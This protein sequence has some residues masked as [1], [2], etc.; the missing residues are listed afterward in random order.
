[1]IAPVVRAGECRVWWADPW[2]QTIGTLTET[3]SE[4]EL[5][6]AGRF[7]R[8]QDRR[9]YLTGAWLLRTVTAR[10]LGIEPGEVS[11]DR[12]CPGCAKMHGKPHIRDTPLH[13]SVT[14]SADRVGVALTTAGPLG[15]DVEAVPAGSFDDLARCALSPAESLAVEAVPERERHAAFTGL[16]VRKEAVLKATGHGLRIPPEQV[17]MT[18]PFDPAP[19]LLR[20]P[21]TI[22]PGGVRI[23]LLHPGAGYAGALAVITDDA[24]SVA[25]SYI[26]RLH[27]ARSAVAVT[28]A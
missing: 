1:M 10:Q 21:L 5:D 16:W 26:G 11:V 18:G 7:H 19:A 13:V 28:A 2:E 4:S 22:P 8:E 15:V 24:V 17:E 23:R 20:W 3:L 6:R 25:E 14:H 12:R 9:R 27:T